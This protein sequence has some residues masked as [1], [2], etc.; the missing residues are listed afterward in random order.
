MTYLGML[1]F[2]Y[3]LNQV[4]DIDLDRSGE[5]IITAIDHQR[6]SAFAEINDIKS[7]AM[8]IAQTEPGSFELVADQ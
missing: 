6:L 2:A 3:W 7:S 1:S 4:E 5:E 8:L